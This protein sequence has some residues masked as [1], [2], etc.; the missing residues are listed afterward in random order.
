MFSRNA[1][2]HCTLV[3]KDRPCCRSFISLAGSCCCHLL[4]QVVLSGIYRTQYSCKVSAGAGTRALAFG[5][6]VKLSIV[7]FKQLIC[8][9][10][11]NAVLNQLRLI[12]PAKAT[13]AAR[14]FSTA[15]WR[16]P[17][18]IRCR[19]PAAAH[20][21]R[22]STQPKQAAN[23]SETAAWRG[24]LCNQSAAALNFSHSSK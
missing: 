16:S 13:A 4:F 19:R 22:H 14:F 12:H 5:L 2:S 10:H 7:D 1:Q 3:V 20:S 15:S 17:H 9:A 24:P 18:S 11:S 8:L 6:P 21:Q 23:P